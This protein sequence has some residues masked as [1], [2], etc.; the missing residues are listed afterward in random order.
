M[1]AGADEFDLIRRHF[2]WASARS[3][4]ALGVGD[5]A[6]LI[7]PPAGH[8]LAIG[9][10]MLIAA[11]HFPDATP[12]EAVA[13]KALAVNLSDLAAM[14]ALPLA[15]TLSL[16]LP[17]VDAAWLER[18]SSGLRHAAD[19]WGCDL[20][21][22]DTVGAP[23][24][25]LSITAFGAVPSGKAIR[26][27]GASAGDRIAVTGTIGD[28]AL[29]LLLALGQA[30]APATLVPGDGDYLRARLDHPE[31][32]LATG[33]ALRDRAT[34]GLDISDGLLQ[35]LGHLLAASGLAAEIDLDAIPLSGAARRWLDDRPE[36]LDRLIS[37]G[38]DYELVVA[39]PP[40]LELDPAW[41]LTVIGRLRDEWAVGEIRERSGRPLPGQR[42]YN[43]FQGSDA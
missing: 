7:D 39:L 17:D 13:H 3:E 23:R 38:D 12:P 5:D 11:R 36:D 1:A 33:Q 15:F 35:D 6:A 32:R 28:A 30:E 40:S 4:V 18:F 41:G 21:G 37:G 19:C 29:G 43:H 16:G 34:A 14:G 9:T 27:S 26:R 22:G 20:I 24:L 2:D 31:P 8:Q 10:D 25:T 42:G